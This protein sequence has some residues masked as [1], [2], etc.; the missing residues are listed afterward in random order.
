MRALA[1]RTS[2]GQTQPERPRSPHNCTLDEFGDIQ[3]QGSQIRVTDTVSCD[4]HGVW[5][6]AIKPRTTMCGR[7]SLVCTSA[8]P[9]AP[10]I[11]QGRWRGSTGA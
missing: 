10:E 8:S 9:R 7:V 4:R 11:A 5:P 1:A 6:L 3:N 2:R